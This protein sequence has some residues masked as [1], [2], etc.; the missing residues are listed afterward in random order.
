M[1]STPFDD[2]ASIV[3]VTSV[4]DGVL[5][6]GVMVKVAL[7]YSPG[8]KVSLSR[9]KNTCYMSLDLQGFSLYVF[10]ICKV[11]H[12]LKFGPTYVAR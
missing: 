9:E 5:A 1:E 3:R 12:K 6:G 10:I 7:V 8:V 2:F 11:M 4:P